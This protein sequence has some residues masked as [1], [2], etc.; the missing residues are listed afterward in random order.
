[1]TRTLISVTQEAEPERSQ[2]ESK[3]V[4]LVKFFLKIKCGKEGCFVEYLL[5]MCETLSI[6]LTT[7]NTF[8]IFFLCNFI[9][10]KCITQP[11]TRF[12]LETFIIQRRKFEFHVYHEYLTII[13]LQ[14]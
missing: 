10:F 13:T 12:F 3:A 8:Q 6:S 14:N 1:M 9:L 5:G 4:N 11:I 2:S 7:D